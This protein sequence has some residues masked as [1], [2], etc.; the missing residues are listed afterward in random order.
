MSDRT[1]KSFK[2]S[3]TV[4]DWN[5]NGYYDVYFPEPS[6]HTKGAAHGHDMKNP[7]FPGECP[8]IVHD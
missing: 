6:N 2:F 1:Q 8:R 5:T 4:V 7:N 3:G